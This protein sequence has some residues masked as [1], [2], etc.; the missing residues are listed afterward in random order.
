MGRSSLASSIAIQF[1]ASAS[2]PPP[3]YSSA[4]QALTSNGSENIARVLVDNC[5][6][7]PEEHTLLLG[8]RLPC[9]DIA[10]RC[11]YGL[12][13]LLP[14]TSQEAGGQPQLQRESIP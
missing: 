8:E 10:S 12:R 1:D 13:E 2:T 6:N 3:G 11:G 14:L 5:Q 4:R 7:F 9:E